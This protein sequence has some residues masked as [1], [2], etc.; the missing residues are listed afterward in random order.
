MDALA[1]LLSFTREPSLLDKAWMAARYPVDLVASPIKAIVSI[2]TLSF[3][4]IPAFSSYG[5]S[6][7]LLFFYMTWAIL[8]RSNDPIAVELYGTLGIRL[9]FYILPSLLFL[10]FDGLSPSLAANMKEHG[11]PALPMSEEQGGCRGPWWKTSLVSIG[12]V[13]LSV[14]LQI[15]L[16]LLVTRVLHL[17][18]LLKISTTVPFP[19]SIAQDLFIG[20]ILREIL[21]YALHRYLL[22]SDHPTFTD[23]HKTWQHS[24]RAPFSLVAHY[25]HPIAYLI[26]VFV[27]MFLPAVLLRFHVLTYQIY[28]ILVS[29]EETFAYSGYNVLP[30]AFVLGGIAR[31]QEKHLFGDGDGNYGC[32]GLADALMGTSLGTDLVDDVIDEAE[33]KDVGKKAKR[34]ARD[35]G[36]KSQKRAPKSSRKRE[37]SDEEAVEENGEDGRPRRR[38]VGRKAKKD[39][40]D[41]DEDEDERNG[42]GPNDKTDSPVRRSNRAPKNR[43][44]ASDESEPADEE[45]KLQGR[46]TTRRGSQ[47]DRGGSKPRKRSEEDD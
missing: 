43:K 45:P 20:L 36:T 22:H 24:V 40:G 39:R 47:K 5:T 15:G 11:E 12:N 28:L 21:T 44:R 25:D 9:L 29:L 27:P 18:S 14:F 10:A 2:P 31:R 34:K 13:L 37:S 42:G 3:L 32:F 41:G 4:V 1:R 6:I 30:S 8:I 7:N 35:T 19:W 46:S 16:E 33:E 23:L 26:H 17:R 38:G